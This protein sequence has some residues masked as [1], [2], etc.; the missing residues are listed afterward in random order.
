MSNKLDRALYGP[1]W[2]E[3]ILG[4]VLSVALGIVLAAA[5][6]IFKPVTLVREM[7]KEPIPGMVYYF[8]GSHDSAK[9]RRLP[10]KQKAFLKGGSVVLTEDEL[11]L[12]AAP[13]Q[14]PGKVS[15]TPEDGF[16][17]PGLVNVRIHEGTFQVSVPVKVKYSLVGLDTTV[18][19]VTKGKFE[20]DGD[21]YVYEPE[22]VYVGSCPVQRLPMVESFVMGKFFSSA[23]FPADV[24]AA[25]DK[26]SEVSIEG[27]TLKLTAKP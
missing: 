9:A 16:L 12:A 14:T 22:T 24:V 19:V 21:S 8:E 27:A 13:A 15:A 1:S 5:F 7:P 2:T 17:N 3:V 10:E 23:R 6:L 4:A 11:N 26:L 20:K 25:W 18:V